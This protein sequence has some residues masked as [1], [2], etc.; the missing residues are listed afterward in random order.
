MQYYNI[1]LTKLPH[2]SFHKEQTNTRNNGCCHWSPKHVEWDDAHCVNA[3]HEVIL[4]KP[5]LAT[6]FTEV[7]LPTLQR[8]D[9]YLFYEL[10]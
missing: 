7:V 9:N 3:T 6:L 5:V 2:K 4:L 1:C 10:P 8:A